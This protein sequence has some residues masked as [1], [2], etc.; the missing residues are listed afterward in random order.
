VQVVHA[1]RV[2]NVEHVGQDGRHVLEADD[3]QRARHEARAH[4]ARRLQVQVGGN[5]H[6]DTAGE[7]GVLPQHAR[8]RLVCATALP[9]PTRLD[10]DDVELDLRRNRA[11]N[12]KSREG[13]DGNG[14]EGVDDGANLS[15]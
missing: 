3:G 5:A 1:A 9:R 8:V 13:R 12:N 10:V 7:R 11:R 15:R 6:D 2:L 14:E 4:G